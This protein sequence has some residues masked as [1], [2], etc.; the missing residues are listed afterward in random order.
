[1]M[2][3]RFTIARVAAAVCGYRFHFDNESGLQDA[4]AKL[5]G[6]LGIPFEREFDLSPHG[7][8]DFYL[9]ETRVGL[10]VKVKGSPSDVLSQI[11]GYVQHEQIDGLLLVTAR[12]R[13]GR[14]PRLINGKPVDVAGL[15]A[16]MLG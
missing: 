1:M 12:M 10:E 5:L 14:V 15:W 13:L 6:D 2:D 11:H 8:I 16:G 9:P 7:R 3:A 4:V